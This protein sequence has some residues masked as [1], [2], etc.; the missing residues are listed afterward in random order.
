MATQYPAYGAVVAYHG[1]LA[2]YHGPAVME[3]VC[4]CARRWGLGRLALRTPEGE[5]LT[6]VRGTSVTPAGD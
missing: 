3:G 4:G 5:P 6:C 1:S 2:A